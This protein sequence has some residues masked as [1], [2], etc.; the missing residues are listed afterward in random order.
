VVQNFSGQVYVF[1]WWLSRYPSC[2][3][4]ES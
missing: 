1:S 2:R 3:Y 4:P